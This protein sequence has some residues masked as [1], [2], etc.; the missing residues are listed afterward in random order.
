VPLPHA[1]LTDDQRQA[2]ELRF[3]LQ[4]MSVAETAATMGRSEEAVKKLRARA[5]VNLRR[6]LTPAPTP[7][8]VLVAA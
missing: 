4:G 1:R 7:L 3:L 8:R 2:V 5:L 6:F